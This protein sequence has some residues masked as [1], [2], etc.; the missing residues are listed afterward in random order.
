MPV[1]GCILILS[2]LL[3]VLSIQLK[4]DPSLLRHAH[5]VVDD[6][7][8]SRSRIHWLDGENMSRSP[9][10]ANDLLEDWR[11]FFLIVIFYVDHW[12]Q[13]ARR[14]LYVTRKGIIRPIHPMH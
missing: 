14:I 10:L 3:V 5:S 2:L 6:Y 11:P 13:E 12:L 9:P 4:L 1:S 7:C 8:L